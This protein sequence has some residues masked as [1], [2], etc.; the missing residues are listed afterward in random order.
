MLEIILDRS[1]R[2]YRPGETILAAI[3]WDT[4]ASPRR[5]SMELRWDTEGKGTSD[6][7]VVAEE[8]WTDL[9]TRGTRTWSVRLP[10]G[11][12]SA[13]GQLLQI[14]WSIRCSIDGRDSHAIPLILSPTR[15]AMRLYRVEVPN[16]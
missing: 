15:L 6:H 11:P 8:T 16:P 12:F 9:S 4:E 1:D 2:S 3:R 5:I 7:G 14:Q 10:R 13:Q